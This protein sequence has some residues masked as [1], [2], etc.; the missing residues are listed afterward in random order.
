MLGP[1]NR[2]FHSPL[3][4]M[5]MN[6]VVRFPE[7]A[8]LAAFMAACLLSIG[9]SAAVEPPDEAMPK[10]ERSTAPLVAPDPLAGTLPISPAVTGPYAKG[11]LA[12]LLPPRTDSP[13][14]WQA[15][16]EP[17]HA[18]GDPRW[19]SP[20]IPPPPCHPA[21]PPQPFDLIGV[22]GMPTRGPR[23]RG[24]CCPR[25]GTHDDGPFPCMHRLHDRAFDWFYRPK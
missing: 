22:D 25:T 13:W 17:L 21:C 2:F 1:R 8:A 9:T 11:E 3:H 15:G 20:C 19:L 6:T 4:D 14:D 23:Y 18:C 24:P 7:H 10:D 5:Q 12:S 16:L